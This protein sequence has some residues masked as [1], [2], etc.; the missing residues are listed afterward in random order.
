MGFLGIQLLVKSLR[1]SYTGWY[2]SVILHGVVSP[3]V[4]EFG[5]QGLVLGD[6]RG[7]SPI[8]LTVVSPTR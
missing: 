1:S 6:K 5:A 2:P 4:S 3:E 7:K 8:H